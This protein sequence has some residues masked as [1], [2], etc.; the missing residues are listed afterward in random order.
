V[1]YLV[2]LLEAVV[3]G[4][5]VARP[6]APDEPG[7]DEVLAV[8]RRI[9]GPERLTHLRAL[10]DRS[11]AVAGLFGERLGQ[12]GVDVAHYRQIGSS[13][14]GELA[15]CLDSTRRGGRW[16]GL[17]RELDTDFLALADLLAGVGDRAFA[18]PAS[19]AI[20]GPGGDGRTRSH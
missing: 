9:A 6:P 12:A 2:A 1:A 18:T 10:G 3:G 20:S 15:Q 14:Y 19:D 13:A 7:L 16:A 4:A 17:F 5:E 11:L 8:A